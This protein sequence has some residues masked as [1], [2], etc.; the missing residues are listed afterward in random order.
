M[1][2]ILV[3]A[4]KDSFGGVTVRVVS[5]RHQA[6]YRAA[7]AVYLGEGADPSVLLQY[8]DCVEQFVGSYVPRRKRRDL[9][10]GWA[11][12]FLIDPWDFGHHL[13]YDAHEVDLG[14]RRTADVPAGA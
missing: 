4:E 8:E 12:R 1:S 3:E 10:E 7:L 14:P 6:R 11:V 9:R 5:E 13:G 2:R